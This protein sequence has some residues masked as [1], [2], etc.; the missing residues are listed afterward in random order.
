MQAGSH[1][2]QE[3]RFRWGTRCMQ[4]IYIEMWKSLA[5]QEGDENAAEAVSRASFYI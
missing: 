2:V 1:R 4:L 5:G 3:G